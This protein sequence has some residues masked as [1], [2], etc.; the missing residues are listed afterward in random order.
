[1]KSWATY[2]CLSAGR[3]ARLARKIEASI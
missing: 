2:C 3:A 1:L